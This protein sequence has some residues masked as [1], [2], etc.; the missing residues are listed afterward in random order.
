MAVLT[1]AFLARNGKSLEKVIKSET[2]GY[3]ETVLVAL[4][5]GP[6]DYDAHLLH[7][8]CS[9]FRSFWY[10]CSIRRT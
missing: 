8:V 9:L 3:Y 1:A 6:L 2:S 10:S 7:E 4:S 5:K